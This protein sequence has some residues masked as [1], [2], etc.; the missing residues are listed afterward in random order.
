[1]STKKP[2]IKKIEYESILL[3]EPNVKSIKKVAISLL[4][5]SREENMPNNPMEQA[6]LKEDKNYFF[7][8]LTRIILNWTGAGFIDEI[9]SL[10]SGIR[11]AIHEN[12]DEPYF[13]TDVSLH[14]NITGRLQL[15]NHFISVFLETVNIPK[16]LGQLSGKM[17]WQIF[18]MKFYKQ[19]KSMTVKEFAL[20]L[21]DKYKN[22]TICS[23]LNNMT[24]M[25]LF[26]KIQNS[27]KVDTYQ[28]T[29]DGSFVARFLINKDS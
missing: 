14:Q 3:M 6:Q 15:L 23:A 20:F 12:S 27:D 5:R 8:E 9:Q 2:P 17:A 4:Y 25:G 21:D 11:A 28:L 18:I 24:E 10:L 13:L 16:Y 29:W 1:M 19:Q 22:S 26:S 7:V